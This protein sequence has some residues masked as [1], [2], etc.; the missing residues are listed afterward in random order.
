[1]VMMMVDGSYRIPISVF[2][3]YKLFAK[4]YKRR[5]C[6][7]YLLRAYKYLMLLSDWKTVSLPWI[8][9]C[10][11]KYEFLVNRCMHYEYCR[12]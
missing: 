4:S 5:I 10:Y 11:G 2:I 6:I 7:F 3:D 8:C 12:L 1:M 9:I